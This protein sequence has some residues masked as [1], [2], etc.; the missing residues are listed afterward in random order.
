MQILSV[1]LKNF[2]THRDRYFEFQPGTNAICG[3]NGAGKTSLLEAIAWA[4]FNHQGDYAKEDLIRNGSSSAQV[5]V[6]FIS[7]RDQRTYEVQRCTQRG[8]TLYDPQLN[9]RLPYTRIKDEVLPWLRQHL[10]VGP[11]TDLAQ[12][13]ARTIGVPQGTFTAD[14]LQTAE[15]RKTVFDAILKV[16]EYKAAY[17][18]MNSLRRYAENQVESVKQEIAQYE[19]ALQALPDLQARQQAVAQEIQANQAQLQALELALADLQEQR[20]RLQAEAQKLQALSS[21][22]QTL[23]SQIEG[24]TQVSARLRQSLEQAKQ[25]TAIC[26]ANQAAYEQYQAAEAQLQALSKQQ[27]ARQTLQTQ[28]RAVQK[29][30]EKKQAV[31]TRLQVQL[32]SLDSTA[33]ELTRLQPLAQ[34]QSQ[35]EQQLSEVQQQLQA[36]HPISLQLQHLQQQSQQSQQQAATLETALGR[37]Q[38]LK[39]LVEEIAEL[40]QQCDRI[41]Q[42]LSRLEA[43]RQFEQELQTL[44]TN[45]QTDIGQYKTQADEALQTLASLQATTPVLSATAVTALKSAIESGVALNHTLVSQV[46]EILQDLASQTDASTLRQRLQDSRKAVEQRYQY[47]G[48]LAQLPVQQQQLV[49]LKTQQQQWQTEQQTLQTRLQAGAPLQEEQRTLNQTLAALGN[50]K[51]QCHLLEKSLQDR[52]Q[53]QTTYNQQSADQQAW[54][55][56]IADLETQLEAFADLDLQVAQQQTIKQT[57][58]TGH[59]LY[60]Q[61]QQAAEQQ[62]QLLAELTATEQTIESLEQ[63][64]SHLQQDYTA[65]QALFDPAALAAI[66]G[67]YGEMRSQADRLS[68]SLPQQQKLLAELEQ[69]LAALQETTQKRNRAEQERLRRDRIKRFVNFARNAY[70]EA[71][72][73]ISE[74]YVQSISREADRLFREL[75]NR[76]NVALEWTRDYEILVQEGPDRRRFINLSGG[77]QMCAALA[78]RLALL[79]VLADI[80]IAFFDE[81]TTNMDRP[82]RESLAEAISRIKSFRQLFVI[83][84]DDTFEK[85]T[86]NVILIE[87]ES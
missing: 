79:K 6:A 57:H 20:G 32:E 12:L 7:S 83:S 48:E 47:R 62:P 73:R 2:K 39:P 17:K 72:P 80:D 56:Q 58:W 37:L 77:E 43:A 59:S 45:S 8:Y 4:L 60:L 30:A 36:L 15:N 64:R 9:E 74:C 75:L 11:G 46:E 70:K 27:Q 19:E 50:P 53:L 13:F 84:H 18:Q 3:E 87:R 81:P 66:E 34:E 86:E 52:S 67:Q 42:Q 61:N 71:G 35:L 25:A 55:Q 31:L 24:K 28:L 41:Q 82:R 49:V 29:Q 85:V 22:L 26:E 76:P 51:G 40:E 54:H 23:G 5:T 65:Q 16:E 1:T 78:V 33:Q 68:G 69:Q 44:V 21:Q 14:F 38:R 10:G 63:Q